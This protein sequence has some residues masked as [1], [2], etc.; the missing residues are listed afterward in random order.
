MVDSFMNSRMLM[1]PLVEVIA[2]TFGRDCSR[3]EEL[4]QASLSAR[5]TAACEQLGI[6]REGC[7]FLLTFLLYS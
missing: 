5:L 7:L 4:M 6:E 1:S 3:S 2:L